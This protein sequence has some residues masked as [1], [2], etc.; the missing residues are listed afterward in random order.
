M[1]ISFNDTPL[2]V[3]PKLQGFDKDLNDADLL[4][5]NN[6]ARALGEFIK[7]ADTPITIGIQGDWGIGK[8][9]MLNTIRSIL[10]RET[11]SK[12]IKNNY[13]IFWLN[14][15]Q[16]S[17]FGQDEYLGLAV[18]KGIIEDLKNEFSIKD[19]NSSLQDALKFSK[20]L[21]KNAQFSVAGFGFKASDG[22]DQSEPQYNDIAVHMKGLKKALENLVIEIVGG[23]KNTE[24]VDKLVF[25][26][27]DLDRVKPIR[28]VELLE[29][30]KNFLDI[31][32]CV[33]VI[34]VDYEVI[35]LGMQ[36]KI[37]VDLQKKSGKSFV[38][39]II[40]L[41]VAMPTSSY[42]LGKYISKLLRASDQRYNEIDTEFYE[43]ITSLTVGRNPRSIKRV[44]N[45][46]SLI[47]KIGEGR[48]T[49][50][51]S[52]RGSIKKDDKELRKIL[53]AL[54]CM[55]IAWP[56]VFNFFAKSPT[57]S[58]I[59]KIE[60]WEEQQNIPFINKLYDRTPNVDLLKSNISAYFDLIYDVLDGDGNG[61]LTQNELEPIWNALYLANLIQDINFHE[62]FDSF[63]NLVENNSSGNK[64]NYNDVISALKKS[65]WLTSNDFEFKLSGTRYVTLVHKRKQ[66]GCLV[67]L[68]TNPL[69]F[70]LNVDR[71]FII[72]HIETDKIIEK[73]DINLNELIMALED[74]SL[75]GFGDTILNLE[76][77]N[78]LDESLKLFVLNQIA[79]SVID[80]IS[81]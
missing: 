77:L 70:R 75:T 6:Y 57:D 32:N 35:E 29:V 80:Y 63:R 78:S 8:T 5:T 20:N 64:K 71:D 45:Y 28:A 56:E 26:I 72:S 76:L 54:I 19:D 43:E 49:D 68:K 3:D 51:N 9:S 37:G 39:K 4:D 66:V 11:S 58:T 25:F 23:S 18:V 73:N 50:L 12:K 36:Q 74:S 33:F 15:W 21:I 10:L 44:I 2:M 61:H 34:A 42:N 69:I 67:T 40:Q 31:P 62:P 41:P 52:L 48:I 27:D 55:Q 7:E 30:L 53:Y 17:M 79:K 47:R 38:D 65:K 13:R 59:K 81:S 60:N 24:S 14:T 1:A 22:M 46:L 16:Y